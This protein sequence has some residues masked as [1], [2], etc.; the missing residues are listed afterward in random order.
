V[1]T[2][3]I[4]GNLATNGQYLT[5]NGIG[6]PEFA[7][8]DLDAIPTPFIF[9]GEPWNL[10][11]RLGPGGCFGACGNTR[12]PLDPFPSSGLHP[13]QQA[14]FF[15]AG[16]AS[17]PLSYF[18]FGTNDVL[19]FPPVNGCLSSNIPPGA[20]GTAPP[21]IVENLVITQTRFVLSTNTWRFSG[22][23]NNPG[24]TIT[25]YLGSNTSGPV[26]GSTV[27]AADGSFLFREINSPL[28][29]TQGVDTHVTYRTA[30]GTQVTQPIRY[31]QN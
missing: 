31:L 26:I 2:R 20:F 15:P 11:R 8:I 7:E 16:A 3:D 18:P 1:V 12:Q 30:Q 23:L 4:Q 24:T 5:P 17:R 27:V 10:D 14:A 25:F 19:P 29:P 21:P 9:E 6:H 13:S 28:V 22:T